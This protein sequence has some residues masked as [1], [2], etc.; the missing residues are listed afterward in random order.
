MSTHKTYTEGAFDNYDII[1]ACGQYQKDE[2]RKRE[3][4]KKLKRKTVIVSGYLY[5]DYLNNYKNKF[6]L[7]N[8]EKNNFNRPILEYGWK[9]FNK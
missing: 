9:R 7:N 1:F 6:N 3:K 8:K 5:L 4:L 2:I